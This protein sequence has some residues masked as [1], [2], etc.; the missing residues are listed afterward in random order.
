M[1]ARLKK[2]EAENKDLVD[3][4]ME[5][6]LKDAER[7]NEVRRVFFPLGFAVLCLGCCVDSI[8]GFRKWERG[9]RT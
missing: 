3:R 6:K 1:E 2:V 5:Q 8:R 9:I 7:L 4:W